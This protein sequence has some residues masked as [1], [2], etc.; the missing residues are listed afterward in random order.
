MSGASSF[1]RRVMENRVKYDCYNAT[2]LYEIRVFDHPE[3]ILFRFVDD[4]ECWLDVDGSFRDGRVAH[5][6][7]PL[8]TMAQRW[9]GCRGGE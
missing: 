9:A 2:G 7:R 1:E 4:S 5:A 6:G 8:P 3:T